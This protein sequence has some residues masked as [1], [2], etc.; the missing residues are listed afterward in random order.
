MSKTSE[1]R[2]ALYDTFL[3]SAAVQS[4]HTQD[5]ID[6]IFKDFAAILR[7]HTGMSSADVDLALAD[8]RTRAEAASEEAFDDL[9]PIKAAVSDAVE[10]VVE[11]L[12]EEDQPW[13][14]IK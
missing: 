2:D 12:G 5:V 14:R 10:A 11:L 1:L 8:A 3:M 13:P 4:D 6:A 7:R 9:I